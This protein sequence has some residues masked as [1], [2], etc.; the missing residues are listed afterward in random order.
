MVTVLVEQCGADVDAA[1]RRGDRPL[2]D[3]VRD[4]RDDVAAYLRG[5]GALSRGI[6]KAAPGP[7]C[8]QSCQT[9]LADLADLAA[10]VA[11][12]P[13]SSE[14]ACGTSGPKSWAAIKVARRLSARRPSLAQQAVAKADKAVAKCQRVSVV[15]GSSDELCARELQLELLDLDAPPEA[16]AAPLAPN[17]NLNPGLN[18]DPSS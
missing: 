10:A 2:D 3:A 5:K 14:G 9:D 1:D 16:R 11:A 4:S 8:D 13:P 6:T 15:H 12:V 7:Q 17:L 18:P